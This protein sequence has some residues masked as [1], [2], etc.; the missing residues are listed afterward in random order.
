MQ[1]ACS[2]QR[3]ACAV[4]L[5]SFLN[6]AWSNSGRFV[7]RLFSYPKRTSRRWLPLM[8]IWAILQALRLDNR[9]TPFWEVH[10]VPQRSA[11]VRPAAC[12]RNGSTLTGIVKSAIGMRDGWQSWSRSLR[13]QVKQAPDSKIPPPPPYLHAQPN[14]AAFLF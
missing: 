14:P 12:T 2:E 6:P 13:Q 10:N 5:K 3:A 4:D 9:S 11:T 7:I 8:G 1:Q